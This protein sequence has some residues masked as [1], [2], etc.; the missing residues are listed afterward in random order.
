MSFQLFLTGWMNEISIMGL[1][2]FLIVNFNYNMKIIYMQLLKLI[3]LTPSNTPDF[4]YTKSKEHCF[5]LSTIQQ[6]TP[7]IKEEQLLRFV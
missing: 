3:A 7:I 1:Y 2:T 6:K 5:V 4:K